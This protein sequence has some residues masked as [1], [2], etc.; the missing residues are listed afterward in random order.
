MKTQQWTTIDKSAWPRGEWDNEPDKV[1]WPDADTGLPC[2]AVR[3]SAFGHWCGYVGV[4]PGHPQHGKGYDYVD[5]E[6]HGGLTFANTCR[7]GDDEAHGICHV[8]E[9]GE[10]DD[11]YW[12]GF[13]CGHG[14]DTSP[15]YLARY[16]QFPDPK[17]ATYKTLAYVQAQCAALAKQLASK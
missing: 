17:E 1:Q 11:V 7:P 12:L 10:P 6:V 13:D 15:A 9:P 8:P 4:P 2:L 3:N 16:P 14:W 5:A